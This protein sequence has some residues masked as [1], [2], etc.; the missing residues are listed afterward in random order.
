MNTALMHMNVMLG[1]GA[2]D[3]TLTLRYMAVDMTKLQYWLW[4]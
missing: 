4:A 3:V 1:Y 2:I